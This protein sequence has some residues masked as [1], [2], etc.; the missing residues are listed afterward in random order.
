MAAFSRERLIQLEIEKEK[1]HLMLSK[2]LKDISPVWK[3]FEG[4][5]SRLKASDET[6]LNYEAYFLFLKKEREREKENIFIYW[7]WN[8]E[9]DA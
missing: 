2:A 8:A 5:E 1:A 3:V 4:R 9:P 7:I 6:F